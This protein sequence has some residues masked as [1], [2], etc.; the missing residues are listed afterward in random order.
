MEAGE[1]RLA[2]EWRPGGSDAWTGV[3]S[4]R[5]IDRTRCRI[6]AMRKHAAGRS[7]R[8]RRTVSTTALLVADQSGRAR[9]VAAVGA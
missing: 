6:L 4:R 9:G 5:S 3:W 2:V 1:E 8:C 7:Q